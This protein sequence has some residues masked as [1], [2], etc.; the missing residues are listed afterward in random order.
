LIQANESILLK[1]QL[2]L[3]NKLILDIS[4]LSQT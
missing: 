1:E 4:K 3:I 2:E